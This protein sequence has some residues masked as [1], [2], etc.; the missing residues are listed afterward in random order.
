MPTRTSTTEAPMATERLLRLLQFGDSALPVGSFNFSN[1]LESAIAR[2]GVHDL[3]SLR[4]FLDTVARQAVG[5]DG[6]ALLVAHRAAL[7]GDLARVVEAD[8]TLLARKLNV[9]MRSMSVRMGRKL[10]ELSR[11]V[12]P[13]AL[14]ER[15]LGEIQ[16]ERSPGSYAVGLALVLAG[17]GASEEEAFA[18]HHYGVLSMVL[19]SALRLMKVTHLETQGLLFERSATVSDDYRS[20]AGA[21]LEDMAGF[22][23][24]LD[25]LAAAHVS[26]HVRLFMS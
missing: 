19:G 20:I 3:P 14:T 9:E 4:S 23:P 10:A 25:V 2:G 11:S 5:C 16:A 15:W 12:H 6:I 1:G 18:V 8:R 24:L 7:A 22:A 13:D 26:S 21:K 17:L